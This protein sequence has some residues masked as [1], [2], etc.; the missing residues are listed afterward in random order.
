MSK[1]RC[2]IGY[3]KL[4]QLVVSLGRRQVPTSRVPPTGPPTRGQHVEAE[5][6]AAS[7]VKACAQHGDAGPTSSCHAFLNKGRS[8]CSLSSIATC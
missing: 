1:P 4:G 2:E 3:E 6:P 5:A 8:N 7:P